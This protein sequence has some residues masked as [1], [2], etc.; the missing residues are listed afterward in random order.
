MG[1][2][3]RF[4]DAA[5]LWAVLPRS[6]EIAS[7]LVRLGHFGDRLRILPPGS[8]FVNTSS[9]ARAVVRP[10]LSP[11]AEDGDVRA[12]L[13]GRARRPRR[14]AEVAPPRRTRRSTRARDVNSRARVR[15]QSRRAPRASSPCRR[16]PSGKARATR[17]P[18]G[19]LARARARRARGF[20]ASARRPRAHPRASRSSAMSPRRRDLVEPAAQLVLPALGAPAPAVFSA[21]VAGFPWPRELV[22]ACREATIA[23]RAAARCA[24]PST[25]SRGAREDVAKADTC[26]WTWTRSGAARRRCLRRRRE[27]LRAATA[28]STRSTPPAGR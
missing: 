9:R 4:V 18:R 2:C 12:F 27:R 26:W 25:P 10:R 21:C 15:A 19:R 1:E 3:R 17:P 6:T 28:L 23:S 24:V 11:P 22:R 13:G 20:D 7:E 5:F 14:W 16:P 8:S